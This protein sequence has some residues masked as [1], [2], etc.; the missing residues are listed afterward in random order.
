[1]SGLK[2]VDPILFAG[3]ND[4]YSYLSLIGDGY[5]PTLPVV[6]R[7]RD[8]GETLY[9]GTIVTNGEYDGERYSIAKV[10]WSREGGAGDVTA[11][12]A[13][14]PETEI[15]VVVN[16]AQVPDENTPHCVPIVPPI[17]DPCT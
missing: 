8:G 2:R 9:E 14:P 6:I 10:K 5:K 12:L 3:N 1:M 17:G 11:M 16:G 7:R 15:E 4:G 13:P